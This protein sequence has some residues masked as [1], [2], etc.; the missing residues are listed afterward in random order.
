MDVT[1]KKNLLRKLSDQHLL[2]PAT[3]LP[4]PARRA[5]LG[6]QETGVP[7]APQ[8]TPEFQVSLDHQD[9]CQILRHG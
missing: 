6:L 2:I 7:R 5:A 1:G 4:P 3:A 8:A 9:P